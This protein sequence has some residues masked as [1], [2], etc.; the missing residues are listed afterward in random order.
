MKSNRI[1]S[2]DQLYNL[3]ELQKL[4]ISN[5][6]LSEI[7]EQIGTLQKLSVLDVAGNRLKNIDV[8]NNIKNL[9]ELYAGSNKLTQTPNLDGMEQLQILSLT[10]NAF[11]KTGKYRN[12]VCFA[13]AGYFKKLFE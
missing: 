13:G 10:N 1:D 5:N 9:T 12:T 7:G 4:V 8:V 6:N 2:M 11:E 3:P